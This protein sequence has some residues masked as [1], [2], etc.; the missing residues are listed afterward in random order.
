[1][2]VELP[3]ADE[4]ADNIV[5]FWRPADAAGRR[6]ASN[7]FAYRL[8]WGLAEGEELPLAR[9]VATRSGLSILDARERVFVVDFDLGMI[10]FATV[11]PR[12]EASAGEVK[13]L[14]IAPLPGGN[15]ARVGFHFV[16]GDLTSRRVPPLARQRGHPGLGDLALPLERLTRDPADRFASGVSPC[17]PVPGRAQARP[18]CLPPPA[19]LTFRPPA[20]GTCMHRACLVHM[21]ALRNAVN[22][23]RAA[24]PSDGFR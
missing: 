10:N 12:L 11:E 18:A 24:I 8:T 4:F 21:R 14:S 22:P 15:I 5:A 3:S 9:V 2:L 13:G 23:C 20:H 6:V 7:A 17:R 1:M 19:S 16:A